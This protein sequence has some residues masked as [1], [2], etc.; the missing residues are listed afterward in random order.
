MT[1][2]KAVQFAQ[3]GI[4]GQILCGREHLNSLE[5]SSLPEVKQAIADHDFLAA[6]FEVGEK[7]IR[8]KCGRV[9]YSFAG[10]R[11]NIDS[12]KSKA[13]ILLCWVDEAEAVSEKAWQKLIPTVREENSEVW[14][15]WNPETK[16]SATDL[17]FRNDPPD[18]AKIIELNYRDNPKFPKVLERDRLEDQ[19]KRPDT[20]DHVWEGA[21]LEIIEG[22]YYKDQLKAMR[23]EGRLA[24]LPHVEG[25]GCWTFW[26]IGNADGTAIWVVQE[27]QGQYR[28]IDFYECWGKPYAEPVKWLQSLGYVWECMYLPHDATHERQG[29]KD[30]RSA[31]QMLKEL[32]PSV[33][34]AI[35]PR[36]P[37][38][39][40][41]IQHMRDVF[42]LVW[43]DEDKCAKGVD[44]VRKYRRKWS[45]NEKR[46]LNVPD[47]SEG[48]SEAADALRQLAQ[49]HAGGLLNRK[50]SWGKRR[51]RKL[52]GIA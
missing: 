47:K 38:L 37:E 33:E 49:A 1:A 45:E 9:Y 51:R 22:A 40:W 6:N 23:E 14:L 39:M 34:W 41:G 19:E 20:Y 17:R 11:H 42:P 29:K 13:R 48:H 16:G 52:K 27:V 32:M 18:D 5:E 50:K 15:T 7:Y 25:K 26:D 28:C 10:L 35:V 4:S 2:V 21:Y 31:Q 8:T 46:W 36:I 24:T 43:I 44:H 30:N 12:I 3:A